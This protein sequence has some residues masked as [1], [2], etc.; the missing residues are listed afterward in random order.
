MTLDWSFPSQPQDVPES[1]F[2][3]VH[4][5]DSVQDTSFLDLFEY[6]D[7]SLPASG[8]VLSLWTPSLC[9]CRD[10]F[11]SFCYEH[12]RLTTIKY[13]TDATF[14]DEVPVGFSHHFSHA[15]KDVESP[16]QCNVP[17][18]TDLEM[19]THATLERCSQG[20]FAQQDSGVQQNRVQIDQASATKP[21]H[22][23]KISIAQ[24]TKLEAR[25][26]VDPY[27]DKKHVDDLARALGLTLRTIRTWFNNARSRKMSRHT[28]QSSSDSNESSLPTISSSLSVSEASLAVLNRLSPKSSNSSLDK[29]LSTPHGDGAVSTSPIEAVLQRNPSV[30]MNWPPPPS[31]RPA[32][33]I[34]SENSWVSTDSFRSCASQWSIDTRGSRRGRK[35]WRRPS[36]LSTVAIKD[37]HRGS[38]PQSR[39]STDAERADRISCLAG[40]ERVAVSDRKSGG[41][42]QEV[43]S[44]LSD[45][46]NRPRSEAIA[47]TEGLSRR[48]SSDRACTD[49]INSV[50]TIFEEA[51]KVPRPF[52][53]TWLGCDMTFRY[54]FDWSRHE[55]AIRYCP[56]HWICDMNHYQGT[57]DSLYCHTCKGRNQAAK[58]PACGC[59]AADVSARMFLREDQLAQHIKRVHLRPENLGTTFSKEYLSSRK[60]DNPALPE[61]ALHCGFC[62]T[63]SATWAERQDHVYAHLQNG[64]C[65]SSWW[66]D[67][68]PEVYGAR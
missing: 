34:G 59:D 4:D 31:S 53:C 42:S 5:L 6:A 43:S 33:I 32:S 26:A 37:G 49:N 41:I 11:T 65:K 19:D 66:P 8:D 21:S 47:P 55:E 46:E 61:S 24:R 60:F 17:G 40:L 52:F 58:Q 2:F 22:R 29:F 10:S 1:N 18:P 57:S 23:T 28:S 54:R 35:L 9:T 45:V 67:R 63:I 48:S 15:R 27:P 25:F 36:E 38:F 64:N 44:R 68:C 39:V 20:A 14:T 13:V 56:H 3:D 16:L 12:E 62:G 30:L 50:K 7:G 51:T